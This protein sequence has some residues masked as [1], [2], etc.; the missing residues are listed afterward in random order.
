MRLFVF[1]AF[2]LS[3]L[4]TVA[5]SGTQRREAVDLP[6]FE[7]QIS[8]NK[9]WDKSLGDPYAAIFSPIAS[10]ER[11]CGASAYSVLCFDIETGRKIY[12]VAFDEK[13]SGG[14]GVADGEI[15][16]GGEDGMVSLMDSNGVVRWQSNIGNS[17]MGAPMAAGQT[18]IARDVQ[19][20]LVGLD[21]DT[22]EFNWD[23]QAPSQS[24]IL[25]SNPGLG[26]GLS[27]SIIAGFHGGIAMNLDSSAGEVLWSV[28]VSIPSGDNE[29]ERISDVVG[30]PLVLKDV[31]CMAT[32]Q[33]RVSCF[34]IETGQPNWS[35]RVSAVGSLGYDDERVFVSDEAGYVMALDRNTGAVLW[36]NE[37][38]RYRK[39][40]GP[41]VMG[42]WL[43]VGDLEGIISAISVVDG[44]YVGR[45]KTDGSPILTNPIAT[46]N[47]L[48]V[49]TSEGNL[50][51]FGIDQNF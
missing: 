7:Q 34:D 44:S 26:V 13:I 48:L 38:F 28:N 4:I 51:T 35:V 15:F 24:L 9:I 42:S 6:E 23:F 45:T 21:R 39:I 17:V 12:E 32:F 43:M 8:L 2:V 37:S 31:V 47:E 30:T 49:Q 27:D 20:R 10:A 46:D 40:T 25:R 16:L 1:C 3:T 33:G 29:L 11:V 41:T 18:V 19:G 14:L 22:G 5:C 36:R 50:Y